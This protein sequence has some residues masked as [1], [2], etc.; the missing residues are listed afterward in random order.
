MI[1]IVIDPWRMV[2]LT[3]AAAALA[4]CAW[5]LLGTRGGWAWL[6]RRNRGPSPYAVWERSRPWWAR[7]A[8]FAAPAAV[9]FA[10][11]AAGTALDLAARLGIIGLLEGLI[12]CTLVRLHRTARTLAG[13]PT[14]KE[15]P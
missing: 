5:Y 1:V 4:L 13:R 10:V 7:A 12:A 3:E 14:G 15:A 9:A 2:Q 6:R 8:A 11:L